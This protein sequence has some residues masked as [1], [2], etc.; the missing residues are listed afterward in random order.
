LLRDRRSFSLLD[1]RGVA[2]L[3]LCPDMAHALWGSLSAP[4]PD[5][6]DPLYLLRRDRESAGTPPDLGARACDAVD[7][8]DLL[9]GWTTLAF[10]LGVAVN[11]RDGRRRLNNRLPAYRVWNRVSKLLIGRAVDLFAPHDTI[12]SDRLH[13]VIL[14]ALLG[15]K[16]VALD[17]CYGKT[18]SY[19]SL[20]MQDMPSIDVRRHVTAERQ[21]DEAAA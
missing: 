13:A 5:R 16:A 20:W 19:V 2:N 21:R 11:Q 4:Q 12:V 14:A 7:W 10:R 15:R 17:N 6:T 9:T 8:D 1:E 18:S 3:L